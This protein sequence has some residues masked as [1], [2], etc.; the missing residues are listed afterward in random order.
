[1]V[2]ALQYNDFTSQ[3]FGHTVLWNVQLQLRNADCENPIP[4]LLPD[5]ESEHLEGRLEPQGRSHDQHLLQTGR[6][7]TL[8]QR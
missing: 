4:E 3:L 6:I 8:Q 1:M 7:R 2:V 5:E